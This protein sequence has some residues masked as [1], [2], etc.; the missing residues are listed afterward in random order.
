MGMSRTTAVKLIVPYLSIACSQ[1]CWLNCPP[2]GSSRCDE[3]WNNTPLALVMVQ[4]HYELVAALQDTTSLIILHKTSMV[5]IKGVWLGNHLCT[6]VYCSMEHSVLSQQMKKF[7]KLLHFRGQKCLRNVIS[8]T[9][10]LKVAW[11]LHINMV[12]N[13]DDHTFSESASLAKSVKI[14]LEKIVWHTI[15]ENYIQTILAMFVIIFHEHFK[16]AIHKTCELQ[17]FMISPLWHLQH[18]T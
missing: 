11:I 16:T 13:G 15:Y 3:A 14:L 5:I 1:P 9:W 4:P 8:W 12:E 6:P 10:R 18:F 7:H 2:C 17:E